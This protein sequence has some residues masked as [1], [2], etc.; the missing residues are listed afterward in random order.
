MKLNKIYCAL[1]SLFVAITTVAQDDFNRYAQTI[2]C[3]NLGLYSFYHQIIAENAEA[4]TQNNL[5]D[6]EIEFSHLWG[7]DGVGNKWDIGVKQSFDWPGSY[8]SRKRE[9]ELIKGAKGLMFDESYRTTL[10]DVKLCMLDLI[11]ANRSIELLGNVLTTLDSLNV[12]YNRAAQRGDVSILDVNKLAVEKIAV[13]RQLGD[14]KIQKEKALSTLSSLNGGKPLQEFDFLHYPA[15]ALLPLDKYLES[16]QINNPKLS[17]NNMM[18]S[19]A[20][21]SEKTSK[22]MSLPGFSVG[23]MH[24]YEMGERFNG[25]SIGVTLPFFSNRR[26]TTVARAMALTYDGNSKEIAT[27]AECAITEGYNSALLLRK[28][29]DDYEPIL[30][31]GR[32]LVLLEKALNGGQISLV[33]YLQE[34]NFFLSAKADYYQVLEQYYK[35][36]VTLSQYD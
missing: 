33:Q 18:K 20:E 16:A 11:S 4:D 27:Q 9:R 35:Q 31:S 12:I 15:L 30:E 19:A 34:L 24:E 6:P 2:V 29:I 21:Q 1:L 8:K 3:N 32:N 17:Y 10:L 14:A 25:F 7:Q 22:L 26:K 36:L 13:K 28:E 5:A 23:Y